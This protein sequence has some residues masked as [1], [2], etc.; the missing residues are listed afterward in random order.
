MKKIF[1]LII[2]IF[3]I[4]LL[5]GCTDTSTMENINIYT[6]AYPFKYVTEQLYGEQAEQFFNSLI[7]EDLPEQNLNGDDVDEMDDL[8]NNFD[9]YLFPT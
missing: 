9:K 1:S 7:A 3:S 2:C 6:T 5:S 4:I 8:F